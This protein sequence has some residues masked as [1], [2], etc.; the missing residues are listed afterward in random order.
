MKALNSSQKDDDEMQNQLNQMIIEFK[1]EKTV[2]KNSLKEMQDKNDE[3]E[4]A[5]K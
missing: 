3:D 5:L 4:K 1:R 2:L